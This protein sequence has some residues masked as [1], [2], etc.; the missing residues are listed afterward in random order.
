MSDSDDRRRDDPPKSGGEGPAPDGEEAPREH[1]HGLVEEIREE[2]H[3]AVEHVPAPVRWTIRRIVGLAV[4]AF[5][6]LVALVVAS[7]I[8]YVVNRTEWV[9]KEV[10]LIL[11]QALAARSDVDL[12]IG[13]LRGNPLTGVRVVRPVVRFREG[14]AP[15]LLEAEALTL[16]YSAWGLLSGGAGPIEVELH[17]PVIQIARGADGKPRFPK[18]VAGKS[19]GARARR[20]DVRLTIRDGRVRAPGFEPGIDGLELRTAV[21]LGAG[22]RVNLERMSWK[23]GPWGNPLERLRASLEVGDSVRVRV[24]ELKSRELALTASAA[25]KSGSPERRLRAV[26]ERVRW[27]WLAVVFDNGAFDV[28]G[29]ARFEVD[30]IESRGWRGD[31]R[32]DLVWNELPALGNGQFSYTGGT[33][34]LTGVDARTPVGNVRGRFDMVGKA[35]DLNARAERADPRGWKA[36]H[37]DGWPEGD[38]NGAFRITQSATK[39]MVLTAQ[40]GPSTLAGWRADSARVTFRAP[41]ATTDTF[42]VDFRRRGGAVRL[43][44]GTR[45]WGWLGRWEASDFPLEEW[46]DGGKSGLV[47]VL[48]EG[49]GDVVSRDGTLDV[50]GELAGDRAAWLGASFRDWTLRGVRGR[51]L[52]TPD[53][54]AET[55]LD[56]MMFLGLHFD[57]T[58]ARIRLG[59]ARAELDSVT[60]FAGDTVIVMRG[61][62]AWRP[63]GWDLTLDHAVATS[64]QFAWTADPPLLLRGDPRGVVFE[65]VAAR[66][67]EASF[68]ARGRWAAAGGQYDFDG[69]GRALDLARL[70]LPVDWGLAGRADA[71]LRVRGPNGDPVWSFEARGMRPGQGGHVA[72]SIGLSL[73]GGRHR[74]DVRRFRFAALG[75]TL[76]GSGRFERTARAWPDTLTGDGVLR[77]LASAA[78][79]QGAVRSDGIA[80]EGLD[81][82]APKPVGWTGRLA[83]D[84]TIGGR[85]SDPALDVKLAVEPFAWK[86]FRVDRLSADASFA[87]GRLR[88][89]PFQAARGGVVSTVNGEM[90]LRLALGEKVSVPEAPM[91]WE[92]RIPGGD[93]AILPAFVPQIGWSRGRFDLDARMT[94]TARHPRL[95]GTLEVR[96]G[97]LRLAGR[98]EVLENLVARMHFDERRLSLDSL[99]ARQGREGRVTGRGGLDLEGLALKGYRF[100]LALRNFTAKEEGLYAAEID[101]DFVVTNG[102]RAR[103]AALP[104]VVGNV[105]VRH[106]AVLFDFANQSEAQMLAASTKPLY[107]TY[108]VKLD[109]SRNLR[110]QPP[111]GDIEFSADLTL[112]QTADSLLIYGDLR[113]ERGTYYFLSNRF[114]VLRADLNFD[115][116]SG[117]NPQLDIEAVAR[118]VPTQVPIGELGA[119]SDRPHDVTAYI[120]GRAAEPQ[121]SFASD[122]PDWDEPQILRELTVGRFIDK[123]GVPSTDPL[124]HYLTRAINRTMSAEMSRAFRGYV[125]EWAL[126]RDRGGLLSGQ[127]DLVLGVGTQLTPNLSLRY[128]QVLPGLGRGYTGP[129]EAGTL[130]QRQVEAEYRLS[131]FF[132]LTTELAQRRLGVASSSPASTADF[133]VNL[134]ARWEY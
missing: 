38:L 103:G 15:P 2:I 82:L 95:A 19:Q 57:S 36:F 128:R 92:A 121:V 131:R 115:N 68:S 60:A 119:G 34:A 32:A 59:D 7:A 132:Y 64:R 44:A 133:N 71:D 45:S 89:A 42:T 22:T 52:P 86:E 97:A 43:L 66:D 48:R 28:P 120:T 16:R 129:S 90:P 4:L 47:G 33:L 70:G 53:L 58:R 62:S 8:L 79:W 117:V 10:T 98:E 101:G 122:P 94:G 100:D 80:L 18:W 17:R 85:P 72:D 107:W 77:W 14:N 63:E 111:D 49:R 12:A 124:E 3:E 31:F 51:L 46:P 96:D 123:S 41:S 20:L 116:E 37:L 69:S 134:K 104:Q 110:W 105:N 113:G 9:A 102:P 130:F 106:A 67:G 23:N 24:H 126:E 6:G 56:D 27:A 114:N 29:T 26:V 11:N 54:T 99:D 21:A 13:D 78:A 39:D 40:L 1:P 25:W 84:L 88:V 61:R 76:A 50:T 65:R 83:G 125:N 87:G 55:G 93:F 30:A 127:G 5:F 109:A 74:L 91:N 35:W 112:E 73:E 75:G 81:R 118:V 108:R